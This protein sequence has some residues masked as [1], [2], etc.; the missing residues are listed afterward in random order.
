[1]PGAF[2]AVGPPCG[3]GLHVERSEPEVLVRATV[4]ARLHPEARIAGVPAHAA[5]AVAGQ[6]A[7]D[8]QVAEE[9]RRRHR[10]GR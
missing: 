4:Q 10:Q 8:E 6:G 9:S 3:V 5:H 1:M 2:V 7:S